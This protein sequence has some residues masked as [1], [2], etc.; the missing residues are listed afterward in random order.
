MTRAILNLFFGRRLARQ[1]SQYLDEIASAPVR[2]SREVAGRVITEL[3]AIQDSKVTVGR[4]EWN[5]EVAVP[6][7][8][9]LKGHSLIT[10]STGSGKSRFVLGIVKALIEDSPARAF[11]ILDAK[12]EVFNG[13]V[14]LFARRLAELK[15]T[16]PHAAES[17]RNRIVVIDFGR[18]DPISPYHILAKGSH[19]EP[20][21]FA[22]NRTDLLLD[23]LPGDDALSLAG[24]ALLRR[25]IMVLSTCK[26]PITAAGRFSS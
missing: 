4:T 25:I 21:F 17:L 11:G 20:G 12:S 7:S 15:K 1:T 14:A 8:D 10:G 2:Q 13:A 26:L 22:E 19:V 24:V 3:A 6:M 9:I 18:R 16:D 23:L 5:Q